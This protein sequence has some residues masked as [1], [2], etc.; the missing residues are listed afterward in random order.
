M[1]ISPVLLSATDTARFTHLFARITQEEDGYVVQ[2]RLHN[3]ATPRPE[4]TA[5]G[6]EIADSMEAASEMIAG[7]AASFS[8]PQDRITLEIRMDDVA[9]STRH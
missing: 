4:S 6:E 2:V 3:D 7:L 1:S 9:Q 8:I 5:W